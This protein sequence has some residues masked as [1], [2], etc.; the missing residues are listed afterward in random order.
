MPRVIQRPELRTVTLVVNTFY[1]S[2]ETK[3]MTI[4]KP[5]GKCA[6]ITTTLTI[7]DFN[8]KSERNCSKSQWLFHS[9]GDVARFVRN[10]GQ[11]A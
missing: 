2:Y 10:V 8:T 7:E 1:Y 9:S 4:Y 11:L 6:K 5:D 3:Q